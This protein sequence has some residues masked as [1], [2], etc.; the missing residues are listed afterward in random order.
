MSD[1]E[2]RVSDM[3]GWHADP[4]RRHGE[5]YFSAGTP[6]KLVRDGSVE[7][8]DEPPPG[9][10]EPPAGPPQPAVVP[11]DGAA[12]AGH[13]A[14][15]DV[16]PPRYSAAYA[17]EPRRR[18]VAGVFM[19]TVFTALAAGM[20]ILVIAT[21][22]RSQPS[23][24]KATTLTPVAP[25]AGIAPAAFVTQ[26]ARQTLAQRTA[27]LTMSGTARQAGQ[28]MA[29]HVTGAADFTSGD[30]TLDVRYSYPRTPATVQFKEIMAGGNLYITVNVKGM[31]V[32][33]GGP[34]WYKQQA[35]HTSAFDGAPSEVLTALAGRGNTAR[36]LGTR[37]IDGVTCSGYSVTLKSPA[38]SLV[39]W[40]DAQSLVREISMDMPGTGSGGTRGG[41]IAV[42]FSDFGAPAR[43]TPPPPSD[44]ASS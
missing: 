44:I 8:Y 21:M 11:S 17:P 18:T 4:F 32:R 33:A 26:A 14:A 36:A 22:A 35:D 29:I 5:R 43:I 2:Q 15:G 31:P 24:G 20:V 9:P 3:Q 34:R 41:T 27:H 16:A 37:T 30:L 40:I 28:A 42:D 12:Q 6:T 39:V 38:E 7:S 23:A 25:G 10:W 19:G 1:E 13:H